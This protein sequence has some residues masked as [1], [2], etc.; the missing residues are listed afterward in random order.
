ML[1]YT[2]A[3]V[4]EPEPTQ[5]GEAEPVVIDDPKATGHT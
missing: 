5:S 1:T 2:F 3:R 4:S